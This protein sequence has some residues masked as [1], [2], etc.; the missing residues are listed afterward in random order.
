MNERR[1]DLAV[2]VEVG[3]IAEQINGVREHLRGMAELHTERHTE[4]KLSIGEV[5]QFAQEAADT[6]EKRFDKHEQEERPIIEALKRRMYIAL[7]ALVVIGW[8]IYY[9]FDVLKSIAPTFI[10]QGGP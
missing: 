4:L 6:V 9:I 5:K 2:E 10:H 3:R 7:G 1:S 8:V